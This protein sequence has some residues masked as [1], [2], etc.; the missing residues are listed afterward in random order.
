MISSKSLTIAGGYIGIPPSSGLEML[1]V[2]ITNPLPNV[3]E[4]HKADGSSTF[5]TIPCPA[6]TPGPPGPGGPP[7]PAVP[8]ILQLS[9][10]PSTIA[11]EA[12]T[13][14]TLSYISGPAFGTNVQY[15]IMIVDADGKV[16]SKGGHWHNFIPGTSVDETIR[17][18]GVGTAT[19]TGGVTDTDAP[20]ITITVTA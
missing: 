9:A 16:E 17:V 4:I 14:I 1:V 8:I 2:D 6:S 15:S 12:S 19:V 7:G 13:K 10:D 11:A 5:I 3:L 18:K 20:Q